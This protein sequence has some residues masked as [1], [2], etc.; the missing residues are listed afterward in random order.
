MFELHGDQSKHQK[1]RESHRFAHYKKRDQT[2][3]KLWRNFFDQ[4]YRKAFQKVLEIFMAGS[5]GQIA[6]KSVWVLSQERYWYNRSDIGTENVATWRGAGNV[7][8]S[9]LYV[10]LDVEMAFNFIPRKSI[11]EAVKLSIKRID[12]Y[13]RAHSSI[14][15]NG[16]QDLTGCSRCQ[17]ELCI[18]TTKFYFC[19]V[20]NFL[21]RTEHLAY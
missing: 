18:F 5:G 9:S 12:K 1:N 15:Y 4:P 16:Q 21:P 17:T 13:Y 20:T 2:L 14:L 3:S 10:F 19:T 11:Q 7:I 6:Q 8:M